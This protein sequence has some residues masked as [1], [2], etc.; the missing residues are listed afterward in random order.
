MMEESKEKLVN[1]QALEEKPRKTKP[2]GRR[3]DTAEQKAQ[4]RMA[5][6]L[7]PVKDIVNLTPARKKAMEKARITRDLKREYRRTNDEQ[8][9]YEL[10]I[11]INNMTPNKVEVPSIANKD[12]KEKIK[13]QNPA[14][15]EEGLPDYILDHNPTLKNVDQ[16][17]Y[18]DKMLQWSNSQEQQKLWSGKLNALETKMNNLDNYLSK[19]RVL[20]GEGDNSDYANRANVKQ[21]HYIIPHAQKITPNQPI[22]GGNPFHSNLMFR[23]AVLKKKS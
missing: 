8:R 17:E 7:N 9:K 12:L 21:N 1:I 23:N 15:K 16:P 19:I 2:A 14:Y 11:Q 10:A 22:F 5:K 4:K 18:A 6:N 20:S 13:Y 3:P